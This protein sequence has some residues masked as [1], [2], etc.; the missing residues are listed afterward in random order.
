M[1]EADG[2]ACPGEGYVFKRDPQRFEQRDIGRSAP[3]VMLSGDDVAKL[4]D[5][6]PA[7]SPGGDQVAWLKDPDDNILGISQHAGPASK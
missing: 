4:D 7:Q 2:K 6:R 3:A 5:V 1:L